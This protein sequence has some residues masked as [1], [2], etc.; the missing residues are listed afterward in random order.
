M[1]GSGRFLPLLNNAILLVDQTVQ[2][3]RA[4]RGTH[5]VSLEAVRRRRRPKVVPRC[6]SPEPGS[7]TQVFVELLGFLR[8][9]V[10]I[11]CRCSAVL[12]GA[13]PS[14]SISISDARPIHILYIL[15]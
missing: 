15:C 10:L 13:Q 3:R 14:A 4:G 6:N 8:T 9:A 7:F 1:A 5:D 11:G 12:Y 2:L